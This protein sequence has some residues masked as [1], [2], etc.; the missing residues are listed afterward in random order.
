M[1][2]GFAQFRIALLDL[3]E[4]AHVLDS[5]HGLVGEG[6]QQFDLFIGEWPDL[7]S[8][9][10]ND[11]DGQA[12]AKQRRREYRAN[13]AW[14]LLTSHRFR[15]LCLRLYRDVTDMNRLP[16]EYRATASRTAPD[17][18]GLP[19]CK[20]GRDRPVA[21]HFSLQVT[22]DSINLSIMGIT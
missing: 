4:Q 6:L 15:K 8:A 13:A 21:R 20:D 16:V 7:S 1:F 5:D 10:M 17:R 11:P 22:L 3:L 12:F 9:N 14:W 2:Q 18:P 19:D